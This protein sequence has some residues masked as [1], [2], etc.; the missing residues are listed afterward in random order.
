MKTIL[1]KNTG[2]N[3]YEIDQV[4]HAVAE[5]GA[6]SANY[7]ILRLPYGNKE[8][9]SDWL[10]ANFP[11]R[12]EKI[13]NKVKDMRGGELNDARFGH[14]MR[15]EGAYVKSIEQMF[16]LAKKKHGLD[17]GLPPMTTRHFRTTT[18]DQL[19]LF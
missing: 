17:R 16:R 10:A 18:G 15:G 2:L 6:T 3:D 7:T 4:L 11:D 14:R 12:K 19:S 8:V 1:L 5:A 9:F 13:L